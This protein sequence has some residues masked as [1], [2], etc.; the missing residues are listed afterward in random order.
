MLSML[1]FEDEAE[2]VELANDVIHG[3]TVA[4]W[5]RDIVRANRMTFSTMKCASGYR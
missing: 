3:L 2:A 5:T 1:T 4:V